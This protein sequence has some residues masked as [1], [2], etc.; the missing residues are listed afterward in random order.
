MKHINLERYNVPTKL[1]GGA[2]K[3]TVTLI[4]SLITTN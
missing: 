1:H 2:T 4:T 3:K